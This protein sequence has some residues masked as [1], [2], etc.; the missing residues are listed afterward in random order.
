M[1]VKGQ[2]LL[3]PNYD[4]FSEG[5]PSLYESTER[6]DPIQKLWE[7]IYYDDSGQ[8]NKVAGP[9]AAIIDDVT[10]GIPF[11][12]VF[13]DPPDEPELEGV[14][15]LAVAAELAA[16]APYAVKGVSKMIA[17]P[18]EGVNT[19]KK[20]I[21]SGKEVVKNLWDV[22]GAFGIDGVKDIWKSYSDTY[23]WYQQNPSKHMKP[24]SPLGLMSRTKAVKFENP[25]TMG[26]ATSDYTTGKTYIDFSKDLY[27]QD[28]A[29]T[30]K[31]IGGHEA[32][33]AAQP[34]SFKEI[35]DRI[36]GM[37]KDIHTDW[38]LSSKHVVHTGDMGVYHQYYQ[39][40]TAKR[41]MEFGDELK[42]IDHLL[43]VGEDTFKLKDGNYS[44]IKYINPHSFGKEIQA[45]VQE[46]RNM[47]NIKNRDLNKYEFREHFQNAKLNE[48]NEGRF[49]KIWDEF[50]QLFSGWDNKKGIY[51]ENIIKEG[52]EG[53]NVFLR[54]NNL[55][56]AAVPIGTASM[57]NQQMKQQPM[58]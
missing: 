6:N 2:K 35:G 47:L 23:D 34:Q 22:V 5:S 40:A 18:K 38:D 28:F 33:H 31:N 1:P 37:L 8:V 36:Y 42:H 55:L 3:D 4:H 43:G 44:P 54:L 29:G 7:S 14:R 21:S 53:V 39:G 48:K 19:V 20:A 25:K 56:P 30:I 9:I 58:K 50:S 10:P 41:S 15:N 27:D 12:D 51:G 49:K 24:E 57:Y 32:S 46:I 16:L 26:M 11:V 13:P 52:E 17:N 45:R